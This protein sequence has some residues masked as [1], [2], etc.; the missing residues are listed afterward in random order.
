MTNSNPLPP[1]GLMEIR[2]CILVVDDDESIR[3]VIEDFLSGEGYRVLCARDGSTGLSLIQESPPDLILLDMLMPVMDGRGFAEAYRQ[4][5][6]PHAPIVVLTAT[7]EART[8]AEQLGAHGYLDKPF[9]LEDLLEI[10]QRRLYAQ[11]A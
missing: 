4:F 7:F 5:P 9:A 11:G 2:P 10:V 1:G 6:G 3:E 8:S